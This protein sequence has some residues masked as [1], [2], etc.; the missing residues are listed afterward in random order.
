MLCTGFGLLLFGQEPR[1]VLPQA[2]VLATIHF[3]DGGEEVR[4]FDGPQVFAP[5][6]ALQWLRYR[7]PNRIDR[8]GPRRVEVNQKL[9]ELFREGLVNAII[10]RDYAIS[11]AKCQ[12]VVSD[13]T[14]NV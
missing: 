4:D 10:H 13:D 6:E 3:A 11:G 12:F 8:S 2:G 5:E 7:L 14:I 1:T 9:F